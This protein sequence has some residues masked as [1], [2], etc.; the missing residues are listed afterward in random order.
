MS[1]YPSQFG[2]SP[3]YRDPLGTIP[4]PSPQDIPRV[5]W[6]TQ[7]MKLRWELTETVDTDSVLPLGVGYIYSYTWTSPAFD[8]RP[9]LRSGNAG[10]KDGVP[11]WSNAARLYVQLAV[12]A[13]GTGTQRALSDF[14]PNLIVGGTDFMNTNFNDS[15]NR[16][17]GEGVGA[18]AGLLQGGE[19]NVSSK[20]NPGPQARTAVAGFAPPGTA[21]GGGEGYPIR[22]WRLRLDFSIFVETGAPLPVEAPAPPPLTLQASVY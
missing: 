5:Q 1:D 14:A 19:I 22:F 18:G 8:L 9:D 13:E 6:Y 4:M 7:W 2:R 15:G 17:L 16:R 20:F 21:L 10:V 12:D 11:V 3:L